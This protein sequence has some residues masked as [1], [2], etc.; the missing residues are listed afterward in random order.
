MSV[1]SILFI[2]F[3]S[4][5]ESEFESGLPPNAENMIYP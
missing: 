1:N 2:K 3:E 5:S 4:E